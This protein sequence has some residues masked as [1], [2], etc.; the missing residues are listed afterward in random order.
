MVGL[1][2]ALSASAAGGMRIALPLLLIGLLRI[3]KLW[4][5]IPLLSRVHPQ[6][7]ISI[8]VSWSLLEVFASKTFVGQR[9]LQVVQI[10]F[11]PIV[12]AIMGIAIAQVSAI[13][14]MILHPGMLCIIGIV[15]GLL[16]LVLQL[17]QAGWLYRLHILPI[18]VIFLQ[19]VLCISLVLFAFDAPKEGALIAMLLLWLAIRS[20]KEWYRWYRSQ[21]VPGDGGNPRRHKRNPD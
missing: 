10:I 6:V 3:D 5:E 16:A 12:G 8:L 18:W 15:G 9:V 14:E 21:G 11:S 19:D 4:S 20:S 13:D 2:A 7:V 1:L 17:V